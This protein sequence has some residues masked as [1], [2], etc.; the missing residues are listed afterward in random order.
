ME[1]S[2]QI[3]QPTQVVQAG[4]KAKRAPS[5]FA[6]FVGSKRAKELLA[7]HSDKSSNRMKELGKYWK[8]SDILS[9][10]SK[11]K[12]Q[13]RAKKD[14]EAA[15]K[16]NKARVSSK[17]KSTKVSKNPWIAHVAKVRPALTK[18][19]RAKGLKGTEIGQYVVVN[20]SKTYKKKA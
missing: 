3:E 10:R 6:R 11:S 18:E 7:K 16:S 9:L 19:A 17:K 12:F 4:G 2:Q 8:D 15:K 13:A 1:A 5:A 20:A 14:S